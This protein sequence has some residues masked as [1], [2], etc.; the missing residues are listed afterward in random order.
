[1]VRSTDNRIFGWI[2]R[3]RLVTGG[4][5]IV[6]IILLFGVV[7]S[8]FVPRGM[9]DVGA[10]RVAKSPTIDHLLGTDQ[11]GRDVLADI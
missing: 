4:I 11:Q 6:V 7:G 5:T 1:M 8:L 3:Y 9:A 10:G 2:N